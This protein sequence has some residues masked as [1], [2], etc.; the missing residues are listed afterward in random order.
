MKLFFLMLLYGIAA[1]AWQSV[2]Q[3][4]VHF[5]F[6]AVVYMGFYRTW[7]EGL[8]GT[9][10][11]G[12]LF[13]SVSYAPF[14]ASIL[15][16]GVVFGLIRFFRRKILFQ[17]VGPRFLWVAVL[18]LIHSVILL[19]LSRHLG[20]N[21]GYCVWTAFLDGAV[22]LFWIPALRRYGA[23]TTKELVEEKDILLK[24]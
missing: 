14:G 10:M 7:R 8:A 22:G 16:F 5:L 21:F 4:P 12:V 11:L 15:S 17:A 18:S 3:F 13:D 9:L 2:W 20:A 6:L 1:I 19:R 24:R 23:M